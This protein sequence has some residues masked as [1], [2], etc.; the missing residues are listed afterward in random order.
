MLDNFIFNCLSFQNGQNLR[1]TVIYRTISLWTSTIKS[2][3]IFMET[4][5][6]FLHYAETPRAS[7]YILSKKISDDTFDLVGTFF[8]PLP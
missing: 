1:S 2:F 5:V 6:D 4:L 7:T 3:I 8:L